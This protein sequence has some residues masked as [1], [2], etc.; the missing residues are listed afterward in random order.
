[1][2]GFE[3][4]FTEEVNLN[5]DSSETPHKDSG[6][7]HQSSDSFWSSKRKEKTA[8]FGGCAFLLVRSLVLFGKRP[9]DAAWLCARKY[10]FMDLLV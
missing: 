9:A 8:N 10:A 3:K 4:K 5:T 7:K 1:M 6:E 2:F